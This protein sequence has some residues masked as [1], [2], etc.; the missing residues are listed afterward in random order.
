MARRMHGVTCR[1][2]RRQMPTMHD[3]FLHRRGS[4]FGRHCT[5][6]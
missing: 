3:L 1:Y 2:C 5:K 4:R 6:R